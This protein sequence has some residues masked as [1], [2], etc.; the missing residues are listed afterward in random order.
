M[1]MGFASDQNSWR[2]Q[3]PFFQKHYQVVTFD[4]RGV[5]KSAKPAGPYTTRMMADDAIG[6]MDYLGIKK[7]HI[8]G[9][10]MGG[11]IAQ[12]IAINHPERVL[13][14]VLGCTYACYDG[15]L[16]GATPEATPAI[17]LALQGKTS[18]LVLLIF[19]RSIYKLIFLPIM[20][21]RSVLMGP[22]SLA[23]FKAQ[24]AAC[25]AHQALDRLSSIK[26]PTLVIV[27]T[28]D[29]LC[30]PTSSEVIAARISEA[31]L[32]KIEGGSHTFMTEIKNSFNK[33]VLNFLKTP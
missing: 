24:W 21:V 3:I 9:V 6:L 5:G 23:G 31:K 17:D 28:K 8:L 19:N 26:S 2:F 13:K 33:E 7:A 22:S 20:K 27:G 1:V 29:R 12:E 10:S 32:V 25:K 18:P 30:K 14:L 11:M 15:G 16:S 4:N